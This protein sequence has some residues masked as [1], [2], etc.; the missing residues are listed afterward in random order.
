MGSERVL[1]GDVS[2]AIQRVDGGRD[3]AEAF[4]RVA[5]DAVGLVGEAGDVER[6]TEPVGEVARLDEGF[7]FVLV[8]CIDHDGDGHRTMSERRV[9]RAPVPAL[10]QE[11]EEEKSLL[12]RSHRRGEVS[13]RLGNDGEVERVG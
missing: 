2:Q 5:K 11:G 12:A 7:H 9:E 3:A 8:G 1:N 10:K 13:R 4:C 6:E